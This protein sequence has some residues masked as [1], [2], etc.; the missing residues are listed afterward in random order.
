[1]ANEPNGEVPEGQL[2]L[3]LD[4]YEGPIDVLLPFAIKDQAHGA[5]SEHSMILAAYGFGGVAGA[6]VM[7]ARK[8]PHRYLTVMMGIWGIASLPMLVFGIA[9]TV[10]PM[11]I[12]GFVLVSV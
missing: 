10:W 8:M 1:M 6:L 5:A 7:A 11:V 2:V 9:E 12:A 4:G 3:D